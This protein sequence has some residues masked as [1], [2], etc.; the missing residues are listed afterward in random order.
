MA[1]S[2]EELRA[3]RHPS[4]AGRFVLTMFVLIPLGI[5]VAALTVATF[6]A[7]LLAAPFILFGLWFSLRVVVASCMNNMVQVTNVSFPEAHEAIEEAKALFGY[8][9]PVQAYVYQDGSYN[10]GILP[11]LN[12][13]VLFLNSELM[14]AENGRDEIRFIVGWFVGALASKHYRFGWLE[15][16]ING[17]EKLMIFNILLFPYERATKLSGDRLGLYMLG[18]DIQTATM[19]MMKMVVGSDIAERANV[20]S[21]VAQGVMYNGSFFSWVARAVSRF[22]HHTTR[23]TQLIMF[24]REKYPDRSKGFIDH[25]R[26]QPEPELA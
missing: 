14:K 21:F 26:D 13:K 19:A 25:W 10:A 9:K 11:L 12:T 15:A 5:L 8:K 1:I 22:P 3:L 6:G 23:V 7:I 16:F 20:K 17:V 4:E 24:A 18:G 2:K